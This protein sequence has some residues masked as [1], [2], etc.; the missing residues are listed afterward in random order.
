MWMNQCFW[1]IEKFS[2]KRTSHF[3][4][5]WSLKEGEKIN[6]V[7]KR[8][9][10]KKICRNFMHLSH[11]DHS[12]YPTIVYIM[13]YS[14]NIHPQFHK[15]NL[16]RTLLVLIMMLLLLADNIYTRNILLLLL[17]L[18]TWNCNNLLPF[19]RTPFKNYLADFF[20]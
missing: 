8:A 7:L 15:K 11:F 12:G 3:I 19:L 6:I 1:W 13:P 16:A 5:N 4:N 18:E 20:R 10:Q 2:V 9:Y 14:E 17:L